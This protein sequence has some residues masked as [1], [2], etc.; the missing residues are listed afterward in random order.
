MKKTPEMMGATEVAEA[1]GVGQTNLRRIPGLPAPVQKI[2]AGSLWRADEI[3]EF[4][5]QREQADRKTAA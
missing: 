5:R 3:R 2:K 4:A 1:L